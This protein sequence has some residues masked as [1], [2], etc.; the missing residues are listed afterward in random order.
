M[1]Q[2]TKIYQKAVQAFL[3]RKYSL[4]WSTCNSALDL[5]SST[6]VPD[7]PFTKRKLLWLLKINLAGFLSVEEVIGS[8]KVLSENGEEKIEAMSKH[9]ATDLVNILWKQ[10]VGG[11]GGL[12]GDVDSEVVVAW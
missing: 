3:L 4:A 2:E 11:F 10:V 8:P 6:P 5:L 7:T 1:R 12:V 9:S